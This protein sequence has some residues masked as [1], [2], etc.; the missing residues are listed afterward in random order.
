MSSDDN[1]INLEKLVP[2]DENVFDQKIVNEVE[3]LEVPP[4]FYSEQWHEYVMR[5][6][7]EEEMEG[8]HPLRDGLV[9]VTEKLLGPIIRR[10]VVNFQSIGSDAYNNNVIVHIRLTINVVDDNHPAYGH[11]IVEDGIAEVNRRNTPAPFHLHPAATASSKAEAQALRK[12]LRLRKMVAAD[13]IT[14]D[15]MVLND[16]PYIPDHPITEE[17]VVVMDLLC[18]RLDVS[19]LDF[20][21]SGQSK[22]VS[23]EQIPTSKAQ[24]MIKFLNEIQSGKQQSPV[25]KKYDHSWREKNH[26]RLNDEST[27][28]S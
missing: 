21:N 10:E 15:D 22:Y 24:S 28:K 20:I 17:Q 26:K 14:P 9:R 16:E 2:D 23:V 3:N 19:L 25:S 12:I 6:F 7:S 18:K 1:E 27:I 8:G 11:N 4:Y 5:Q 13:E